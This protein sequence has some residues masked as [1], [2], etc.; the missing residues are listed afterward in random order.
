MGDGSDDR[1]PRIAD[2]DE[3]YADAYLID[4][5]TGAR[6]LLAKQRGSMTVAFGTLPSIFRR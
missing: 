2:Y 1:I 3:R 4:A 5:G 6:T